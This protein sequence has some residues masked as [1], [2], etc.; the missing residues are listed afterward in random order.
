MLCIFL[1][2]ATDLK[3]W[4]LAIMIVMVIIVVW[5]MWTCECDK[6]K[7]MAPVVALVPAAPTAPVV[8]TPA[9]AAAE[10]KEGFCP[11]MAQ[12]YGMCAGAES[13]SV[14]RGTFYAGKYAKPTASFISAEAFEPFTSGRVGK[15]TMY[16]HNMRATTLPLY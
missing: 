14:N 4:E 3:M 13:M 11:K 5:M 8:T 9:V 6:K 7:M 1:L 16:E 15:G 2:Y 10:K 12:R